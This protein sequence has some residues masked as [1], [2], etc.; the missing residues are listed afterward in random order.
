VEHGNRLTSSRGWV[1]GREPVLVQRQV[2][3]FSA[4]IAHKSVVSNVWLE[5]AVHVSVRI[6]QTGV[7]PDV[8]VKN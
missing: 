5:P 2:P 4:Y 1:R 8:K 7:V 6:R 3:I